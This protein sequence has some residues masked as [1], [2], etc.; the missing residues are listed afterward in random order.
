MHESSGSQFFRN[1]TGIQSGTD[2]SDESAFVM[3]YLT[4]LGLPEKLC[5]FKLV[6]DGKTGKATTKSSRLQFLKRFLASNLL[7]QMQKTTAPGYGV[8]E[9]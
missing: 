7:Y 5:C 4:I 1:T 2:A 3:T 9:V 6:V 8:E